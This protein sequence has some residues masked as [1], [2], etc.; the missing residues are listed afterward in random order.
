MDLRPWIEV[1]G[2]EVAKVLKVILRLS[3]LR[4]ISTPFLLDLNIWVY[5]FIACRISVLLI[6]WFLRLFSHVLSMFYYVMLY[7]SS[8]LEF[9][10]ERH[11]SI[12][13]YY[14]YYYYYYYIYYYLC[15]SLRH[16]ILSL[17]WKCVLVL[18]IFHEQYNKLEGGGLW[19]AKYTVLIYKD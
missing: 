11:I 9:I 4:S 2:L 13:Y 6:F 10:I 3:F 7:H 5:L 15:P 18:V 8:A 19:G 16:W 1:I 17:L 12:V 14:Y